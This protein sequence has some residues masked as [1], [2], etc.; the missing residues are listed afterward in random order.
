MAKRQNNI[1][2][3]NAKEELYGG[4]MTKARV[5]RML[6]GWEIGIAI[7]AITLYGPVVQHAW[8]VLAWMLIVAIYI[9]NVLI[10]R[11]I[12]SDYQMRSQQERNR[13]INIVTQG[14]STKNAN[15]LSV[16]RRA[17]R[18][19]E[20]EFKDD[21]N[22]LV[23]VLVS[24]PDY[25]EQHAAFERIIHKYADDIYFGLFMEQ[26]ETVYHE[27]IYHIE[28]FQ[29]FEDSH[30]KL[31]LKQK[32]FIAQK[33]EVQ[34]IMFT[35]CGIAEFT[36]AATTIGAEGYKVYLSMYALSKAGMVVSTVYLIVLCL[37]VAKFYKNFYNNAVTSY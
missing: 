15:M 36:I 3:M 26:V 4:H 34:H 17:T 20:G 18:K 21:L 12:E 9:Y 35:M 22:A 25:D 14:M 30:N 7:F 16:L 27:S 10:P 8:C 6:I 23:A 28:T 33:R 2:A 11:K 1:V 24:A 29:T 19:A 32:E 37:I 31:L 13:F 5:F